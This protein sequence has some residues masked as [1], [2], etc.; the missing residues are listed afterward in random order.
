MIK[1]VAKDTIEEKILRLQERKAK[2]AESVIEGGAQG[3]ELLTRDGLLALL[4]NEI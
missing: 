1:L 2:L 4:E 3:L